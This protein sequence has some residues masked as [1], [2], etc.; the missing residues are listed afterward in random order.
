MYLYGGYEAGGAG[1]LND[2]MCFDIE[3]K[4]W[5]PV[6]NNKSSI[7]SRHSHSLTASGNKL[8]LFGGIINTF[9]SSNQV[10][11]FEIGTSTDWKEEKCTGSIP[12]PLNSHKA[13][14]YND[15]MIIFGG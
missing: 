12:P 1:I 3:T 6:I 11:S 14:V 10:F 5:K 7:G 2:F 8:Y 9:E 15:E 4:L 13:I